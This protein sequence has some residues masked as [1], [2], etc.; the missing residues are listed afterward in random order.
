MTCRSRPP[1]DAVAKPAQ[2]KRRARIREVHKSASGRRRHCPAG[3]TSSIGSAWQFGQA[4][5]VRSSK[6][7]AGR[8]KDDRPVAAVRKIRAPTRRSGRLPIR[9][10]GPIR[11]AGQ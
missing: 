4:D 1:A 9:A 10:D 2:I 6:K 7:A 11:D 5:S 3:R 8:R